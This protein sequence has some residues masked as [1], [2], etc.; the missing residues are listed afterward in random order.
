MKCDVT[1]LLRVDVDG[2]MMDDQVMHDVWKS[3]KNTDG[4]KMDAV[5]MVTTPHPPSSLPSCSVP[6]VVSES[7]K[8]EVCAGWMDYGNV[9]EARCMMGMEM[10]VWSWLSWI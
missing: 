10:N 5:S 1:F 4:P 2:W 7:C 9:P 6:S 3:R 8:Q